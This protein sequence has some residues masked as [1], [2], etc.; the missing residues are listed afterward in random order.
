M[1]SRTLSLSNEQ[2][3][4]GVAGLVPIAGAIFL[5]FLAASISLA[6]LSIEM[7][8]Q[9]GFGLAAIGW[10][11]FRLSQPHS[12]GTKPTRFPNGEVPAWRCSLDCH[13]PQP[14]G[15]ATPC[16]T[17]AHVRAGLLDVTGPTVGVVVRCALSV[18]GRRHHNRAGPV[19]A[20][21]DQAH[22]RRIAGRYGS[23]PRQFNTERHEP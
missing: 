3:G 8:D 7:S 5:G 10:A 11:A 2:R 17:A 4:T 14:Q 18:P 19:P 12:Q 23:H 15:W 6:A 20:P 16:R 22:P 1:T 9:L 21:V 13:S